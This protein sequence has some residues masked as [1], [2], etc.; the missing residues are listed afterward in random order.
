M[1][2]TVYY[3]RL[4]IPAG[5]GLAAPAT[6]TLRTQPG[7]LIMFRLYVPPGPRGEV[8]L[9]LKHQ[10]SQVAPVPPATWDNLDDDVL[11]YPLDLPLLVNETDLALCGASPNANFEHNVDFEALVESPDALIGAGTPPSLG[12]RILGLFS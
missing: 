4:T 7:R 3:G 8:S 6:L 5:T 10:Q 2:V 1:A 9:W 12:S 11:E